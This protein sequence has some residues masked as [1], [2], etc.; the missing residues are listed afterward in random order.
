VHL[1]A[2]LPLPVLPGLPEARARAVKRRR[3]LDAYSG[4]GGIGMGYHLAGWEVVGID[5]AQMDRYPFEFIK[6]DALEALADAEFLAGFDAIHAS[7]PCQFKATATLSQRMAGAEY[8]NLVPKTRTLLAAQHRPWVMENVPGAVRGDIRLCGCHFGLTLELADGTPGYLKRE[9]WFETSWGAFELEMPHRHIGHAIS[10]AG[11]GTP[12]WMRAKTGHVGVALWR[13][14]MEIQWMD[15][16]ALTE[17]VP[18]AYGEYMGRL[19]SEQ[20]DLAA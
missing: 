8:P 4:Q 20:L 11:H 9:R 3:L 18:P 10:I 15:R 1:P 7:P 5:Q 14:L 19:L 17:A 13:D 12:S 6:R 16:D 2:G